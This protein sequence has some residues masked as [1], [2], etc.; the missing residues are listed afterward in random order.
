MRQIFTVEL[1]T[2]RRVDL[3]GGPCR[4]PVRWHVA[5]G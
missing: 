2:V 4:L 5:V 3:Q 1:H